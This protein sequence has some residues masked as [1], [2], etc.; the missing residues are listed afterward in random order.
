LLSEPS[1][2][3]TGAAAASASAAARLRFLPAKLSSLGNTAAATADASGAPAA[4]A[5][6]PTAAAP[7]DAAALADSAS[8]ASTTFSTAMA[9]ASAIR[10]TCAA[11]APPRPLN[12]ERTAFAARLPALAIAGLVDSKAPTTRSGAPSIADT[13][14]SPA[15]A[16]APTPTRATST[17]HLIPVRVS[18]PTARD[19]T[20]TLATLAPSLPADTAKDPAAPAFSTALIK[21]LIPVGSAAFIASI[22][23]AAPVR[24]APAAPGISRPAAAVEIATAGRRSAPTTRSAKIFICRVTSSDLG[25]PRAHERKGER[26]RRNA[27]VASS[28]DELGASAAITA[29]PAPPAAGFCAAWAIASCAGRLGAAGAGAA[30]A[31]ASCAGRLGAAGTCAGA[32]AGAGAELEAGE[33]VD[34]PVGNIPPT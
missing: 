16:V 32:G 12:A 20:Y 21:M 17:A 2:G 34:F 6:L 29:A 23:F 18:A 14:A 15:L 31:I 7:A 22:V 27:A 3:I 11:R 8:L 24:A 9:F 33:D 30:W 28:Y 10:C 19:A 26:N 13:T 4:A 1:P 25:R 5:A